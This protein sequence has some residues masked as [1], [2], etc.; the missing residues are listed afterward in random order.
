MSKHPFRYINH[1]YIFAI[2]VS[3]QLV[4]P[5]GGFT[6]AYTFQLGAGHLP[7]L[8]SVS[9]PGQQFVVTLHIS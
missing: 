4:Q 9:M 5:E 8:L 7:G 2:Y 3:V 6:L 1:E